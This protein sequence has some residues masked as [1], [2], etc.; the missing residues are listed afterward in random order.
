MIKVKTRAVDDYLKEQ[1]KDPY[2]KEL[3]ELEEQKLEIVKP[4]IEYRIKNNL[5]QGQLARQIQVSQQHISHIESGE[6]SSVATLE[7]VLLFIGYKVRMEAVPLT[8][9][10]K[11]RIQKSLR[12]NATVSHD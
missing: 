11:N 5:T 10:V 12:S 1:L 7:K 8:R 6:F 2:F 4:I 9:T 3:W